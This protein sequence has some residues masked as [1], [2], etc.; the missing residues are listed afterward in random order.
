MNRRSLF[1]FFVGELILSFK[2]WITSVL[3]KHLLI[4]LH[5]RGSKSED[6]L[7]YSVRHKHLDPVLYARLNP[8]VGAFSA[9]RF[10]TKVFFFF[11]FLLHLSWFIV[12]T[13]E[14]EITAKFGRWG[15]FG[16]KRN[17]SNLLHDA[18]VL[19]CEPTYLLTIRL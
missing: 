4:S 6:F 8:V 9:L 19:E 5:G 13:T 3:T 14:V 10:T 2:P 15:E 1:L 11:F 12:T 17:L 7:G 18:L 16:E